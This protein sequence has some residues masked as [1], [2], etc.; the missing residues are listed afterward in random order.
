MDK[1]DRPALAVKKG[2]TV[3]TSQTPTGALAYTVR[4]GDAEVSHTDDTVR[5]RVEVNTIWARSR[6]K[7][8]Q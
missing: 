4:F 2:D 6:G 1:K 5:V 3:F 8:R 7:G